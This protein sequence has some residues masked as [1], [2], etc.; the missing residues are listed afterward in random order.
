MCVSSEVAQLSGRL[1]QTY[2]LAT[3]YK[4]EGGPGRGRWVCGGG[5]MGVEGAVV[6]DGEEI[7]MDALYANCL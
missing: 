6:F 3:G 7:K 4:G 2:C 1:K 5:E